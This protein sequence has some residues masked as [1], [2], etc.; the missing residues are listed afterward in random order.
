MRR[1]LVILSTALL[2]LL[3]GKSDFVGQQSK[4][5]ASRRPAAAPDTLLLEKQQAFVKQYCSG[6][7]NENTKSGNMT[8]TA[9]NLAHVEQSGELAEKVIKKLR[10]GLMPPVMATNRP[11]RSAA[12]EFYKSLETQLDKASAL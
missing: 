2:C 7:H 1:V 11:E 10:T 4:P 9:L 6:C 3:S 8:L 5:A 12:V